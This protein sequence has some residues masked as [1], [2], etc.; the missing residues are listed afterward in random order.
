M[1]SPEPRLKSPEVTEPR[2]KSPEGIKSPKKIKSP[3]PVTSPQRVKSPTP[4]KSPTSQKVDMP[5]KIVHQLKV[6]ACEDKVKMFCVA[7]SRVKEAVWYKDGRRLTQSSCR[8]FHSAADGTCSLIIQELNEKDQGEY[9]CEIIAEGG[10][11][12]TSFSFVGQ[13]YQ[14]IFQKIKTSLESKTAVHKLAMQSS[15]QQTAKKEMVQEESAKMVLMEKSAAT[16]SMHGSFSAMAAH[17]TSSV[18]EASFSSSS[19]SEVKMSS[20]SA[21]SMSSMTSESLLSMSS[22]SSSMMEMASHSQIEGSSMRGITHRIQGTP[23]KIEALPEDISIEKGKVLTVACA[24]SG[25][26]E[27][28]IEW[29]HSGR[30]L[31]GEGG[32]DRFHIETTEDLTTLIITNVKENDAGVYTLKLSNELGSDT[33]MVNISIRLM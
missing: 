8:S 1:K 15:S 28:E 31:P 18:Q 26:P 19:T 3:E 21:A 32:S 9:S 24:F 29:T 20:M 11:S 25:E 14:T 13:V 27:P 5:P 33:A 10:I 22:S 17:M 30:K 12:R 4:V 2:V 7:E 23:P 16:A 6:E